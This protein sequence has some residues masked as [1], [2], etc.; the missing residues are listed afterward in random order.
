VIFVV[1]ASPGEGKKQWT[2]SS[3]QRPHD[4][5][6]SLLPLHDKYLVADL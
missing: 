4:A 3:L 1:F 5:A 2:F 6:Y